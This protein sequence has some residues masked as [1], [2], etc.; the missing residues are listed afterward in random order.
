[1]M[2][3]G[4]GDWRRLIKL[5]GNPSRPMWIAGRIYFISDHGGVGN[6]YSCDPSGQNLR[7]HTE[8]DDFYVRGAGCDGKRIV[9]HAGA[10][11]FVFD[12]TDDQ[13]RK[14]E[15]RYHSPRTQRN[16]KFIE[17]D[18]YL[19]SY[20][21]H[22]QGHLLAADDAREDRGDGQLGRSSAA[23]RRAARRQVSSRAG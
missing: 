16:R 1:S 23:A 14:L 20:A 4:D 18:K 2:P 9:Y 3:V 10:D 17:T 12:P 19:E 6:L 7:Q 22:S 11:L 8:H 21:P 13:S 15:V 5:Q